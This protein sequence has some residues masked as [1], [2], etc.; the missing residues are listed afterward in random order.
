MKSYVTFFIIAIMSVGLASLLL[1]RDRSK[2]DAPMEIISA[3]ATM[4]SDAGGDAEGGVGDA[5]AITPNVA[6]SIDKPLRVATLGWELAA[7]AAAIVPADG[8]AP[9]APSPPLE[10]APEVTLEAVEARLARGGSDPRGADVA[11]LALP[12][13]VSSYERLRALAPRAFLI[14]GFSRGREEVRAAAGA[15]SKPPPPAEEV[16]MVAESPSTASDTSANPLGSES[17]TVLGLFA[18]DLLGVAPSRLRLIAPGTPEAKA[19]PF[20]ALV[21]GV[22]DERKVAFT[23]ADASR[24]VPIVAVASASIIDARGP[25][26]R[27]WSKA[28]LDGLDRA[29]RNVPAIARRLASKEALPLATGIGGAPEALVLVERLGLIENATVEQQSSWVGPFAKS[30]VSLEKVMQRTWLLARGGGLVTGGAPEPLPID[31]RMVESMPAPKALTSTPSPAEAGG[32][33]P[34]PTS[35]TAMVTYRAIDGDA[36]KVAT[37]MAFLAGVFERANFRVSAKG[38]EKAARSIVA[39]ARDKGVAANRLGT[40]PAEP[41]GAFAAVDVLSPP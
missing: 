29:S 18:V 30:S 34:L 17:A 25:L 11:V 24:F 33:G 38:G 19:A 8:G 6:T 32:F 10:I 31:A 27:E 39:S 23:T 16:K 15:L 36:E 28:W 2:H 40:S 21:K 7:A 13:F 41:Q 14:V 9:A 35:V 26:L 1:T 4:A 22:G 5:S 37:E 12:A 3:P 20:A